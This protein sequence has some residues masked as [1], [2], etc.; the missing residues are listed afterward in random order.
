MVILI[1]R[2]SENVQPR[3][4]LV[5]K[6]EKENVTILHLLM[7]VKV[8]MVMPRNQENVKICPALVRISKN[9]TIFT[10]GDVGGRADVC[11]SSLLGLVSTVHCTLTSKIENA[12]PS[13][14]TNYLWLNFCPTIY[15]VKTV[16]NK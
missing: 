9:L 14:P 7:V 11:I 13:A 6:A 10:S 15:K 16:I 8:V 5:Y 3:A 2:N 1:G 12:S 4:D